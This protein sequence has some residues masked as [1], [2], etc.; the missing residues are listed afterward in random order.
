MIAI[1]HSSATE[2]NKKLVETPGKRG[3]TNSEWLARIKAES[4]LVLLGGASLPHF[5]IR[6]AQ[7]HLRSDLLPSFWSLVGVLQGPK[8]FASVPLE[9]PDVSR[10]PGTNGIQRCLLA[11]YDDPELFPNIAVISFTSDE[12]AIRSNIEHVMRQRGIIDLPGLMLPWLGYVWG[13]GQKGNPLFDSLGLPSSVFAE[14]VYGIARIELTPG[15]S[16]ATSC[17]EAIW[18]A[19]KWWQNFYQSYESTDTETVAATVPAGQYTIRQPMAAV[20]AESTPPVRRSRRR[21]G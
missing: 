20:T 1:R 19:A 16:S 21:R 2:W 11:D 8:S 17:P 6:V 14:A 13:A 15:L 4:G 9:V 3:E 7:S 18:Q 5:R 10:V 12:A